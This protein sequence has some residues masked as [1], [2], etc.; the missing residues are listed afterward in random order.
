[1]ARMFNDEWLML[2]EELSH[3]ACGVEDPRDKD[4]DED[5]EN[6][7]ER[8]RGELLTERR[9]VCYFPAL[10]PLSSMR[11]LPVIMAAASAAR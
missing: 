7:Y 10:Q 2:N 9:I 8:R 5:K 3:R 6:D 1:M 11:V 4:K